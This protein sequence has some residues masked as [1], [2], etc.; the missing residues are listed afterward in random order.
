M[1][2]PRFIITFFIVG[3]LLTQVIPGKASP[4]SAIDGVTGCTFGYSMQPVVPGEWIELQST[5]NSL[6]IPYGDDAVVHVSNIG[7][8][9]PFFENLYTEANVSTNGFISFG[10]Q[11][12][13]NSYATNFSIPGESLPNNMIAGFWDDLAVGGIYNSGAVYFQV[14]GVSPDRKAVFEWY[15]VTK[16]ES[17]DELSFEI[18]ISENGDITF[19]YETLNGVLDQ[20]TVGIEDIDGVDG[21]QLLYNSPGLGSNQSYKLT[22]PGNGAGVKAKPLYQGGFLV[23]GL[24]DLPFTLVNTGTSSDSFHF[25]KVVLEGSTDWQIQV[26]DTN[27]KT[28]INTPAIPPKHAYPA[29]IRVE[30]AESSLLGA[31]IKGRLTIVSNANQAKTFSINFDAAVPAPFVASY[32]DSSAAFIKYIMPERQ[33]TTP[34]FQSFSG[35]SFA[36]SRT[37]GSQYLFS[38]ESIRYGNSSDYENIQKAVLGSTT[39]LIAPIS[40][41]VDHADELDLNNNPI[42]V[43]D[44]NPIIAVAPDGTIGMVFVRSIQNENYEL[45]TNI[46]FARLDSFGNLLPPEMNLTQNDAYYSDLIY[47]RPVITATSNNRFVMAYESIT[48]LGDSSFAKDIDIA[49]VSSEGQ[50]S[51]THITDSQTSGL[52][53]Y[54]PTVT[55]MQDGNVFVA[56]LSL[57]SGMSEMQPSQLKYTIFHSDTGSFDPISSLNAYGEDPQVE[58]LANGTILLAWIKDGSP[59]IGYTMFDPQGTVLMDQPLELVSPNGWKIAN[60]SLTGEV[61]GNGVI[62]WKDEWGY[63]LYY[64]LVRPNGS[65]ITPPMA[66]IQGTDPSNPNIISSSTGK[67]IAPLDNKIFW[68]IFLPTVQK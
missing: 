30:G 64:A 53:F 45:K 1:S 18:V 2:L 7:F 68:K 15:R 28:L 26:V 33:I 36:L 46:Y 34:V 27:K 61:N 60:I 48:P 3:C 9:F 11:N 52:E 43:F 63:F 41:L 22:Y 54:A 14:F 38:W 57:Q 24:V 44:A 13:N 6:S 19:N 17:A 65:P 10:T 29:F 25:Q 16:L 66:F 21:C 58:T 47:N 20:A 59:N 23:N 56:F 42:S 32:V 4:S 50:T 62:T 37:I 40:N 39:G 12:E 8:S 67:G 49:V 35:S 55:R 31:F 5:G 51:P